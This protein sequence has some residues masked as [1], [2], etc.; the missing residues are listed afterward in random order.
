MLISIILCRDSPAKRGSQTSTLRSSR[1]SRVH[2]SAVRTYSASRGKFSASNQSG[3][4]AAVISF[5][6]LR[7]RA[8]KPAGGAGRSFA[9]ILTGAT[10]MAAA[11]TRPR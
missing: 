11:E 3:R 5:H 4:S 1:A 9:L 2:S 10:P 7:S 8:V 6:C